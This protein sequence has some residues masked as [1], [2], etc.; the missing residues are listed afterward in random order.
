ML[1]AWTGAD[2]LDSDLTSI[3]A[4]PEGREW[5]RKRERDMLRHLVRSH[6]LNTMTAHPPESVPAMSPVLVCHSFSTVS[7][8]SR[9]VFH[10][11]DQYSNHPSRSGLWAR[12][13]NV[14]SSLS[15]SWKYIHGVVCTYRYFEWAGC[16]LVAKVFDWDLEGWWFKPWCNH[17]RISALGPLNKALNP[18]LLQEGFSTT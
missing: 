3:S 17:N 16:S 1:A 6:S 10:Q 7:V 15:N 13:D 4:L 9:P 2:V 12:L 5:E 18:A 14:M 11:N 8:T